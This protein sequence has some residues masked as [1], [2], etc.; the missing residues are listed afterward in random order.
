MAI[1]SGPPKDQGEFQTVS[2]P[3]AAPALAGGPS[4]STFQAPPMAT[5]MM[6]ASGQKAGFWIRTVATIIDF[7]LLAIVGGILQRIF[8]GGAAG[9][10][11]IVLDIIYYVAFWTT[12]GQTI[13]H[14]LLGL[15]VITTNGQPLGVAGGIIRYIGRAIGFFVIF[16]GVMWV[17]WDPDKQGWHDKMAHTYVV[18]V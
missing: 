13:G 2:I 4:A 16:L 9:G 18:K 15:K 12:S 6:S 11:T 5:S 7:I 17:G 8:H 1:D 14:K 3:S 10:I